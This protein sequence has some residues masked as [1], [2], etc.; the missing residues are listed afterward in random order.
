MPE[1]LTRPKP[2]S[3]RAVLDHTVADP[4]GTPGLRIEE[5]GYGEKREVAYA[6]PA[7]VR[8]TQEAITG[9]LRANGNNVS[10]SRRKPVPLDEDTGVRLVLTLLATAPVTKP[11]RTALIA[12]GIA[13]MSVE[14]AFYWYAHCASPD[15]SRALKALRIFLA[16]EQ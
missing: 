2:R 6:K 4:D 3:F 12:D 16:D 9:L 7:A 14:E 11:Y 15:S 10:P 1:L 13:R 5:T 8:R